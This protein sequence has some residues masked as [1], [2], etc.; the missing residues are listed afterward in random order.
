MVDTVFTRVYHIPAMG[1]KQAKKSKPTGRPPGLEYVHFR[2]PRPL[3]ERLKRAAASES[4]R[5]GYPVNRSQLVRKLLEAGLDRLESAQEGPR[6]ER[7]PEPLPVRETAPQTE[8]S[9]PTRGRPKGTARPPTD[10]KEPKEVRSAKL[11]KV[12]TKWVPEEP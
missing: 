4:K 5:I 12:G 9:E 8:I 11:V 6:E 2:F 1:K 10:T 3:T 7:Q